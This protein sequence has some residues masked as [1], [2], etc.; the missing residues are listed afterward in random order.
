MQFYAAETWDNDF[1]KKRPKSIMSSVHTVQTSEGWSM[2]KSL[3]EYSL[4]WRHL[5]VGLC[6]KVYDRIK[7]HQSYLKLLH[8]TR[9]RIF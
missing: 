8:F 3:I 4:Q 1:R 9:I 5:T 7:T 2:Y 6:I